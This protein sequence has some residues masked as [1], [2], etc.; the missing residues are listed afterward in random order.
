MCGRFQLSMELDRI[1]ERYGIISTDLDF[2]PKNEF[3]P[4]DK[5]LVIIG[6]NGKKGLAMLKWGFTVSF[7]KRL[8]INARS[9]TASSKPTFRDSFIHRRGLIPVS[10]YYEW[11][12]ENGKKIKY[13][14]YGEEDIFSLACIYKSFTDSSGNRLKEYTILTRPASKEIQDI[15]DRMPVIIDRKYEDVWIDDSI[16]DVSLLNNIIVS[17]NKRLTCKKV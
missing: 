12:N 7:T 15:H 6:D 10:G 17:S 14:I 8:L 4:S 1:L 9:E 3:F 2:A 5:S 11:K 16:K 13:K